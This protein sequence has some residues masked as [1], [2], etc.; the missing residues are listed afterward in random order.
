MLCPYS[1]YIHLWVVRSCQPCVSIEHIK[2]NFTDPGRVIDQ[3]STATALYGF[4]DQSRQTLNTGPSGN[5]D[6]R[7]ALPIQTYSASKRRVRLTGCDLI[8]F[9][10]S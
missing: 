2:V 7:C 8:D 1:Q 3:L 6:V 5:I 9:V 4:P 10:V